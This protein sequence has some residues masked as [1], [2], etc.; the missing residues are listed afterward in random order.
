MGHAIK[1]KFSL[2]VI[3]PKQDSVVAY[4]KLEQALQVLG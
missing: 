4:A 2:I 3:C 1:G